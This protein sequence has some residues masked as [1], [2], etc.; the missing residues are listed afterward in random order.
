MKIHI[1][2][3]NKIYCKK[4]IQNTLLKTKDVDDYH[5]GAASIN[6]NKDQDIVRLTPDDSFSILY[7]YIPVAR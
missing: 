7:I 3:Y 4:N 2:T 6:L 1:N 5:V